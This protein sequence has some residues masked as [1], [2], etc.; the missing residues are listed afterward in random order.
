MGLPTQLGQARIVVLH[1]S[2]QR[3]A[4]LTGVHDATH[5]TTNQRFHSANLLIDDMAATFSTRKPKA[6]PKGEYP[7]R[8][9]APRYFSN[10]FTRKGLALTHLSKCPLRRD[11]LWVPHAGA[12]LRGRDLQRATNDICVA[13]HL[14]RFGT[15]NMD[16]LVEQHSAVVQ[17][18]SITD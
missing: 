11:N 15:Q 7:H 13:P 18:R 17:L 3:Q 16:G 1:L 5:F 8:V 6:S 12:E 2:K 10:V 9:C 4:E 14:A